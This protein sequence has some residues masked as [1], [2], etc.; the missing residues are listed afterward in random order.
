[1]FNKLIDSCGFSFLSFQKII[2]NEHIGNGASGDVYK[3]KYNSIDCIGKCFYLRDY[4]NKKG[5][6]N[7]IYS[8]LWIYQSLKNIQ[9]VSEIIGYSYDE[10]DEYICILM[11]YYTSSSLNDYIQ[12]NDISEKQ[13]LSITKKL[14]NCLKDIHSCHIIHCDIKPHNI[15]YDTLTEN[16]YFID[17]GASVKIDH[18]KTIEIEENM[19]TEGYMSDELSFGTGSYKGDIYS[20]GVT[21]LELWVK[22]IWDIKKNYR[23]DILY[24]LKQLEKINFELSFILRKCL[25]KDINKRISLNT[26]IKHLSKVEI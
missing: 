21:I 10:K 7:D 25:A 4:E 15:I 3:C 9:S 13:K 19:G 23:L 14:C 6:I 8:E 12:K 20:L 1:M 16:I 18:S 17:F 26:L 11:K 22:N 5:F 24:S 2:W